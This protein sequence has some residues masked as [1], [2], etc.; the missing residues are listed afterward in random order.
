MKMHSG[1]GPG[2]SSG[3]CSMTPMR[4]IKQS[5]KVNGSHGA[6]PATCARPA[7]RMHFHEAYYLCSFYSVFSRL[8]SK[9][10]CIAIRNFISRIDLSAIARLKNASAL[11]VIPSLS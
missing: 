8:P 1:S 3:K 10:R 9:S 5:S 7:S 11:T 2:T 6:F 4:S